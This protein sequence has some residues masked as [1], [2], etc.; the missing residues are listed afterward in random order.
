MNTLQTNS[1]YYCTL[2]TY[3]SA[4]TFAISITRSLNSLSLASFIAVMIPIS[5]QFP[6]DY[7]SNYSFFFWIT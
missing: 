1:C 6:R 7:A 4:V 3:I 5:A 2:A